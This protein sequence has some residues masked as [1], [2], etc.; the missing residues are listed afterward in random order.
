MVGSPTPYPLKTAASTK[1]IMGVF[2]DNDTEDKAIVFH[3]VTDL[4]RVFDE[5]LGEDFVIVNSMPRLVAS[6]FYFSLFLVD[7]VDVSQSDFDD[8]EKER[9]IRRRKIHFFFQADKK[10]LRVT[11]PSGPHERMHA[12]LFDAI[13]ANMYA[14]PPM[15]EWSPSAATVYSS[16]DGTSS[17]E[18]DSG[19]YPR[20]GDMSGGDDP[21]PALVIEC[22]ASQS[23]AS[24]HAAM[25][26]WFWASEHRVKVVLAVKLH[27]STR[28]IVIERFTEEHVDPPRPG[29]TSTRSSRAHPPLLLLQPALQQTITIAPVP[30]SNPT[31]YNATRGKLILA[32]ELLYRRAPGPRPDEW[33]VVVSEAKLEEVAQQVWR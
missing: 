24:L 30:Q 28:T 14:V 23:L 33:D 17:K 32:F 7:R 19:G 29:A 3:S 13:R 15:P 26:W 6:L 21:W 25:R 11:L 2:P 10:Q 31:R 12:G 5:M 1:K 8:V 4:Y 22:G 20:N 9:E 27:R 18:G 16:P